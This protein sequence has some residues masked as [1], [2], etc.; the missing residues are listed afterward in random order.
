MRSVD[1]EV[2]AVQCEVRSGKWE[3]WSVREAVRSEKCGV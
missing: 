1:L 2:W 3:V